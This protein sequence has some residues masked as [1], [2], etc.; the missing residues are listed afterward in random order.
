MASNARGYD[1]GFL[2]DTSAHS[3]ELAARLWNWALCKQELC[4]VLG[5]TAVYLYVS[6]GIIEENR[7][8]SS[9]TSWLSRLLFPVWVAGVS[10]Y[11]IIF[12]VLRTLYFFSSNAS[13]HAYPPDFLVFPTAPPPS[14]LM[15]DIV[16]MSSIFAC[17]HVHVDKVNSTTVSS[18][19]RGRCIRVA[20][21]VNVLMIWCMYVQV[22]MLSLRYC[23]SLS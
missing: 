21:Q 16:T 13:V 6:R 7:P 10:I 23:D 20:V 11:C 3:A 5:A 22:C 8:R 12:F 19:Y 9:S 4:F 15:L 1:W 2:S 14:E 18:A 17:V